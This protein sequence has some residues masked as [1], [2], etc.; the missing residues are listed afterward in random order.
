MFKNSNLLKALMLLLV[1]SSVATSCKKDDDKKDVD[2]TGET[3]V[4]GTISGSRTFSADTI[5]TMSGYVVVESGAQLT[6]E[7]GTILKFENGQG[8]D[9]SAL[10]VARGGKIYANGTAAAPIIMTS[11][12]DEITH[13]EIASPNLDE[14]A[15]GLWGGFLV[16][17]Y[18]NVS[19]GDGDTEGYIE[20]LPSG[21]DFGYFGGTNNADNSGSITYVSIR[22]NGIALEANKELQGLTL[23]GVGSGT[24][25]NHVE[26]V[27][28]KDDGIEIFGGTVNLNHIILSYQED[29]GLDLDMNYAGTVNNL[30]VQQEGADADNAGFEFDGP[31]GTTYTSGKF[32]VSNATVRNV[33]GNAGPALLKSG[34]QGTISNCSFEGFSEGITISGGSA[35]ANYVSGDLV[36]TGC[37]FEAA[38]ID[39]IVSG[40]A[41]AGDSTSIITTFSG[42]NTSVTSFT[43]GATLSEF[44]GWTWADAV[45]KL[46]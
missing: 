14:T 3:V 7:A 11:I 25:I 6:I 27:A 4:S 45:G 16:M 22:H 24:V 37:E 32:T 42:A 44:T 10:I 17:G 26:V 2:T 18:A 39:L 20:G 5:Y 15:N 35:T 28:S 13:G 30:V 46:N 1:V 9:A 40:A 29:D 21:R 12:A 41:S 36:V 31:E 33:G 38:S 23:G 43:K 34:A 19:D 8:A